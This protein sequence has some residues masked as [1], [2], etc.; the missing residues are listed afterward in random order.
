VFI[1]GAPA[2]GKTTL[3]HALAPALGAA[4]LD[5]DVATGPLTRLVLELVG[6]TDFSDP[7]VSDL[8]RDRRY[9]TL[10]ALA[11]DITRGGTS[12]VL[13]APFTAERDAAVWTATAARMAVSADPHLVWLTLPPDELARRLVTRGAARDLMK[14]RDPAG[15][16]ASL[17]IDNPSAPHLALDAIRPL[18]ELVA[19]VIAH[20]DLQRSTDGSL[21]GRNPC[22]L[23][24]NGGQPT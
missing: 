13:V 23:L 17:D 16:L 21:Y 15:W 1:G 2:S 19:A 24:H 7:R 4:L 20:L 9:E 14:R 11:V 10:L 5:L 22:D 18:D 6:A 3:G 12:V 8:T